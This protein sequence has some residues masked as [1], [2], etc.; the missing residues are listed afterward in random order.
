MTEPKAARWSLG[1]R[2]AFRFA[3]AYFFL[4]AVPLFL[5]LLRLGGTVLN[6]YTE[7]WDVVVV[8]V[9]EDVLHLPHEMEFAGLDVNNSTYGWVLFLCYLVVSVA[10]TAIWSVL[11]RER[12]GYGRLHPWLRLLLRYQLALAMISYGTLKLIPAQMV[13]P[14]PL[15]ALL[16]QIGNL[17]PNHLLW[18]TVGASPPFE[19]AIGFAELAGGVLLLLPRTTLLGAVVTAANMLL[20]FLLNMCYDVP[21]KLPSLLMFVM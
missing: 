19:R 16:T 17:W 18:W 10:A 11:D 20:V 7:F 1:T 13:A 2:V 8:W 9:K 3:F 4:D 5:S 21:V 15:S 6:K 12:P 14:P